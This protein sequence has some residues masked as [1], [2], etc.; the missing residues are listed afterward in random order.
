M[1]ENSTQD[2]SET[3]EA[4]TQVQNVQ[5]PDGKI[6]AEINF[7]IENDLNLDNFY[8]VNAK[9]GKFTITLSKYL[10]KKI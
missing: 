3:I 9:Q 7:G 6:K 10:E 4:M 5:E 2:T 8:V 1:D